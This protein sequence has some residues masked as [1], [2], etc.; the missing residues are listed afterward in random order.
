MRISTQQMFEIGSTRLVDL[1]SRLQK[2][3]EQIASGRR[4]LSPSDDPIAATRVLD[5]TQSQ[6]VN[7]QYG[8]NRQYATNNLSQVEVTLGGVTELMQ[9]IKET[10]TTA[11]NVKLGDSERAFMAS[12]LDGRLQQLLGLANTRDSA[13]NYVFSGFQS[14]TQPFVQTATGANYQ[15]DLGQQKIQVDAT[16]QMAVSTPGSIV[17]QSG[18]QDIFATLTDLVT[19]LNTPG[20]AGLTV[21][22]DSADADMDIALDR[23]LTVRASVGANLQELEALDNVGSDRDLQY[24]Q[25]LSELQ[26]LD[27]T[28]AITQLTQQ[29]VA[30]EATQKTF[31]KTSSLS[32]FNFM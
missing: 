15:G 30:L 7:K 3:Q 1:Q 21:G 28:Q 9:T 22:L 4:I 8:V 27:Y 12:E 32:L 16:R 17:F 18:G 6:T 19:L 10:I 29:Q 13:G 14:H 26:D 2:T 5:V 24:K 23:V 25:L 11:R 20:T 31:A